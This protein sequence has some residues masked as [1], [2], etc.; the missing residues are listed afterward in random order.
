MTYDR[1]HRRL[2]RD[3]GNAVKLEH[4]QGGPSQA[5]GYLEAAACLTLRAEVAH[6]GA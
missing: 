1:S 5:L 3:N 2:P 4:P 6:N